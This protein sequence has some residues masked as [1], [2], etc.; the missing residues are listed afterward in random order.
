MLAA[1]LSVAATEAAAAG[2]LRLALTAFRTMR[3]MAAGALRMALLSRTAVISAL[4]VA[5]RLPVI[6]LLLA[7]IGRIP[8]LPAFCPID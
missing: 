7:T 6:P 2:K 5:R 8:V 3:G 4:C 1:R